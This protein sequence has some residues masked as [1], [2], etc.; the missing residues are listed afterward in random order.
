MLGEHCDP[1]G[2]GLGFGGQ[3]FAGELT[4][5]EGGLGFRAVRPCRIMEWIVGNAIHL[6]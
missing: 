6:S 5:A 3:G 2:L 4:G 1:C